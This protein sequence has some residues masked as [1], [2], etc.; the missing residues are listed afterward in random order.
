VLLNKGYGFA[1][2]QPRARPVDPDRT[3]F[4]LGSV[5]KTFT[6]IAVM[7]QVEA[8][9]MRLDA[10]VNAYLPEAAQVPDRR[11]MR[12]IQVRDLLTHTPGFEDRA[13]GHLFERDPL[14]LRPLPTY[15]AEERPRRVRAP[16]VL[17]T[18]S[19]YGA[20]LAGA[21]AAG[22]AGLPFPDLIERGVTGPLGM[23]RTT[24]REPYPA[25][26]GLPAPLP[27]ALAADLSRGFRWTGTGFEPRPTEFISHAA[28]AGSASG[29]AGDMARYMLTILGD[30]AAPGGGR[31]YGPQAARAFRTVLQRSAPGV[32]G[33]AHGFMQYSLP[34]GFIGYGHGGATLSFYT[35]L[36]TVPELGLGVFVTTNTDTGRALVERLPASVVARFYA[37]PPGP[38]LPGSPALKARAGDYA[39]TY[40]TTR[41]AYGGLE[42]LAGRLI[43]GAV[44]RVTDDGRLLTPS[45]EGVRAWTVDGPDGARTGRFRSDDGAE[46]LVF[47]MEDGRAVRWY[48]P[49]GG[50]AY[51]R[52]SW[53][54]GVG[55]LGLVA[56]LTLLASVLTIGGALLRLRGHARS[57]AAQGRSAAVEIAAAA[58][59]ILS[60][61]GF[62]AWALSA[63]DPANVLYRWPGPWL[64]LG[65]SAGLLA[66]VLSLVLLALLL[67]AWRVEGRYGWSLGRRMR[68]TATVL[69]FAGAAALLASWGAL[70]PWSA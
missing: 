14:E 66:A 20:V 67:P 38:P 70:E 11:R 24:F 55:L 29:S 45:G 30:G 68:H 42:G 53:M 33:W 69:L 21:A 10:P 32:N 48:A 19:N 46:R 8:G 26:D 56:G 3:L 36:V 57:S 12:P 31:I 59:W 35:S 16:G 64:L 43:G 51:E 40:L 58:L 49:W 6:W 22:A 5:S 50:A 62:A 17:P 41:R 54:Q 63:S 1:G 7:Q 2:Y 37:P 52:R 27:A 65:S 44:V 4:R 18:Y 13:L 39:G 28:P 47:E 15:L 61:V 25:Q 9:R 34:G 60:A 23:T